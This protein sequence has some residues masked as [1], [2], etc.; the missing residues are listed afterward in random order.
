MRKSGASTIIRG[1]PGESTRLA[2]L[3]PPFV[4][5]SPRRKEHDCVALMDRLLFVA[6]RGKDGRGRRRSPCGD[7][8]AGQ[9]TTIALPATATT[10]HAESWSQ[11]PSL[12]THARLLVFWVDDKHGVDEAVG[13]LSGRAVYVVV[14]VEIGQLRQGPGVLFSGVPF[15]VQMTQTP[16]KLPCIGIRSS[17]AF[18]IS[19]WK[20]TSSS[21]FLLSQRDPCSAGKG[22]L[23][24]RLRSWSESLPASCAK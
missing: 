18:C 3:G 14:G 23:E 19:P 4:R 21:A 12:F 2:R 24:G 16:V 22:N 1:L 5:G 8:R 17:Q 15:R 6:A 20:S 9:N 13:L 11:R 10:R 7:Y